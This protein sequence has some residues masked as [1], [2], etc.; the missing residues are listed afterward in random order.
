MK[1]KHAQSIALIKLENN[2][3][4]NNTPE[5]NL[6]KSNLKLN[7]NHNIIENSKYSKLTKEV[8]WSFDYEINYVR[9][10]EENNNQL[11]FIK[12]KN[13][14]DSISNFF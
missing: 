11:V 4:D 1:E 3:A 13:Y 10:D 2:Q 9:F 7:V 12:D 5:K 8:K 14:K 6:Q